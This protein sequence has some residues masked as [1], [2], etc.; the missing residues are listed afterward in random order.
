MGALALSS[1]L[2]STSA[3]FPS[4]TLDFWTNPRYDYEGGED[5]NGEGPNIEA[6]KILRKVEVAF[7]I[8]VNFDFN[9]HINLGPMVCPSLDHD[10]VEL[11]AVERDQVCTDSCTNNR[12]YCE[13]PPK[14]PDH[15]WLKGSRIV[16]E[17]LRR[18]CIWS[19]F[20]N[21]DD[22]ESEKKIFDYLENYHARACDKKGQFK[23]Q[24]CI[25]RAYYD[26]QISDDEMN[27]CFEENGGLVDDGNNKILQQLVMRGRK[28]GVEEI[29]KSASLPLVIINGEHLEEISEVAIFTKI[30]GLIREEDKIDACDDLMMNEQL[31][32]NDNPE[33]IAEETNEVDQEVAE[34]AEENGGTE[35]DGLGMTEEQNEELANEEN[36]EEQ[37]ED[38]EL[39]MG[40]TDTQEAA[41]EAL[42]ENAEAEG[43]ALENAEAEEAEEQEG[44]EEEEELGLEAME[45]L[46]EGMDA[47][48]NTTAQEEG[49]EELPGSP[50]EEWQTPAGEEAPEEGDP[51]TTTEGGFETPLDGIETPE[52]GDPSTEIFNAPPDGEEAP[53]DSDPPTTAE[54]G[55]DTPMD[56]EETPEGGDPPTEGFDAPPD[57]E[58]TPEESDPSTTA[59]EGWDTPVDG[60][61]TPEEGG[62][63]NE[64]EEGFETPMDA[65]ET[66]EEGD[67]SDT[68]E[69]SET[70]F[71]TPEAGGEDEP[72]LGEQEGEDLPANEETQAFNEVESTETEVNLEDEVQE[73]VE[74]RS[75]PSDSLEDIEKIVN[76][77]PLDLDLVDMEVSHLE[78]LNNCGVD[79]ALLMNKL[80]QMGTGGNLKEEL[81][82][83]DADLPLLMTETCPHEEG[84]D[85][86]H[87][88]RNFHGCAMFDLQE[89]I[90]T[91]PSTATGVALRCANAYKNMT[92]EEEESGF[93]PE[94]CIRTVEA[95]SVL[96]RALFGVF[97]Y[98]DKACPCFEKLG[99]GIPECTADV[100]PIPING[101]LVKTQSCLVG[102]WCQTVDHLCQD[103]MA[104]L[105]Q[106]LPPRG[107]K[108]GDMDCDAIFEGCSDVYDQLHPML[109]SAPLPDA[110]IRIAQ[111]SDF[112]GT[113]LVER[114]DVFRH[115][116]G[117][118][119]ELWEGHSKVAEFKSFVQEGVYGIDYQSIPFVTGATGGFVAGIVFAVV[120]IIVRN[121]CICV[122]NCCRRFCDF[123]CCRKKNRRNQRPTSKDYATVTTNGD[124][125]EAYH[126]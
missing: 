48:T 4:V 29:M 12:R 76:L 98:P 75:A 125:V 15:I 62:P 46:E 85:I 9:Q 22:W 53:E 109:N 94:A 39:G 108:P 33:E 49:S 72:S 67:P 8:G 86:L 78:A 60:E 52:E 122:R 80:L 2:I 38:E 16:E 66:L 112:F 119:I 11:S 82:D 54:E 117:Q 34:I 30:C 44:E 35:Q 19:I 5:N 31:G 110:C 70:P 7:G 95:S 99:D 111:G 79:T 24:R 107:T 114:Y 102:Q 1:S 26:A 87:R 55:W 124:D 84:V 118:N 89:V 106:C 28:R 50:E 113:H 13:P 91:F 65:E 63:S 57:A 18:Q 115:Q 121:I 6:Y 43:N 88:L 51:S 20:H 42:V 21:N 69:E 116:C 100:W 123:I 105:N 41:V 23:E 81:D 40:L 64:V 3:R 37:K 74:L 120:F 97:L 45:A 93:I 14:E 101:A 10:G 73:E 47:I 68:M 90:E 32:G 59:E 17:A 104:T 126:D 36:M 92:K 96:G 103:N 83:I 56:G 71:D 27:K 61:E 58:E 77:D 25:S